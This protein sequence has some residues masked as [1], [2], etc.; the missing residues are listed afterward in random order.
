MNEA[1]RNEGIRSSRAAAF[2]A[3]LAV[4]LALLPLV[5]LVARRHSLE[6]WFLRAP[7]HWIYPLQTFACLAV[8]WFFRRHYRFAPWTGIGLAVVLGIVTIAVWIAPARLH[9]VLGLGEGATWWRW[10]G[11]APRTD[12]FD[13]GVF[14]GSPAVWWTVVVLRFV[15]LVVVVP[16]VEEIFWR[17]FLMRWLV[18]PDRPFWEIPFGT[19]RLRAVVVTTVCF[20]LAHQPVDYLG[21]VVFGLAMAWLAVRTRSL[22]ACVIMHAIANLLLGLYVL[23]TRQWGFW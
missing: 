7:E 15:R 13:P 2:I 12:G 10:L 18:D 14:E 21:A 6:P 9:E 4:F 19:Y 23:W 20:A 8:L 3:P 16:L 22:G 5:D 17:G 1:P 11:V